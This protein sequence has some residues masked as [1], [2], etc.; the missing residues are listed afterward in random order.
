MIPFI[1]HWD[2]QKN[3]RR[4]MDEYTENLARFPHAKR[5]DFIGHSNGTYI[6]ASALQRYSTLYVNN[7]LFAG[8]VV[9]KRYPWRQLVDAKRVSKIYNMVATSDWVVA[10]FPRFFE[11]IAEW[12]GET[13]VK[14]AF[15][16]GSAGFRG[17]DDSGRL[18][19]NHR[20]V[21]AKFVS[22]THSSAFD[23]R[24]SPKMHAVVQFAISGDDQ[25]LMGLATSASQDPVL[26]QLSNVS[27]VVWLLLAFLLLGIGYAATA[28]LGWLGLLVYVLILTGVLYSF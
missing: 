26:D 21:D 12:L 27:W 19:P 4:F 5:L 10:L 3:V 28:L 24:E 25:Q 15:D 8:S 23:L 13:S 2:R 11:Q 16:I 22:G 18:D 1:L 7:V 6:L 17:F 9:P 20:I 14:G